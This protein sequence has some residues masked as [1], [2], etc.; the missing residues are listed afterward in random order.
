MILTIHTT[1]QYYKF[2]LQSNSTL[3]THYS[4]VHVY[5]LYYILYNDTF[6]ATRLTRVIYFANSTSI[7]WSCVHGDLSDIRKRILVHNRL[8][9]CRKRTLA[10]PRRMPTELTTSGSNPA[11]SSNSRRLKYSEFSSDCSS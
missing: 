9:S 1:E 10:R 5:S 3:T 6:L 11:S 2:K 7:K 8:A 4:T